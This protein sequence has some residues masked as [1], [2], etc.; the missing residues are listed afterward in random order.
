M[1]STALYAPAHRIGSK[2]PNASPDAAPSMDYGGSGIQDPRLQYNRANGTNNVASTG[3]AVVGWL[4]TPRCK[5]VSQVPS[6]IATANIAALA[7]VVSGTPMTKVSTTGAGITVLSAAFTPYPRYGSPIP[8]GTLAIDGV[9][10]YVRMGVGSVTGYYDP[11]KGIARCISITGVA[12]GTGGTFTVAGY[13]WY[14]YPMTQLVTVGAGVNTVNSTKAFKFISS[15]TPNFT[16]A[17]NY[18]VG[19]ADIFGFNLA[20]DVF[21]DVD[22]YWVGVKQL[23][24]TF[25]A[26]VTTSPATTTTGDVRGTFTAGSASD[27]SKRLDIFVQTPLSRISNA[28]MATGLFGVA[29]V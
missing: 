5:V 25:T 7:N 3:M 14:G 19:T 10:G 6:T 1:A 13:D 20:A 27:N 29:Q 15:I 28:S 4:G 18:S 12:S 22:I 23:L 21:A 17:H 11:T 9:P 24:A 8:A 16:D 2:S 26:A